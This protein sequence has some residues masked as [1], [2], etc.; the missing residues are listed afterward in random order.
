MKS[1][2]IV[3]D[4]GFGDGGKGLVVDHLALR[5]G[6]DLVVR[7]NGGA[8]AAHNVHLGDGRHHT[9]AQLGSATFRGARTL[10]GPNVS[11]HP[12]AL[13]VEARILGGKGVPNPLEGLAIHEDCPLITPFHQAL[14]RLRELARGG[15]R[16]GS[17][18]IGIGEVARDVEEG[19]AVRARHLRDRSSLRMR[20]RRLAEGRLALAAT[21]QLPDSDRVRAELAIFSDPA[22]VE[23]WLDLGCTLPPWLIDEVQAR[24][25]L[26]RAGHVVF[27][28]AQ[29]V[30][31][32]ARWGFHPFTTWS[33]CTFAGA[34]SLLLRWAP[35]QRA[36]RFGVMRA[37]AVRHGPGP[38]PTESAALAA[39][40][41]QEPALADDNASGEWQGPVRYGHWDAGLIAYGL[42]V[43]GGVDVLVTTWMDV[44]PRL[45]HWIYA[46]GWSVGAERRAALPVSGAPSVEGQTALG[47]WLGGATPTLHREAPNEAAVVER[48]EALLG[49][50]PALLARGRRAED[51]GPA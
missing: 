22:L 20:L 51:I 26:G 46:D 33:D 39:K 7:F 34:E 18:G 45:D 12:G 5:T 28:G 11:V 21:L 36:R 3:V 16:H 17:C 8:Q 48:I 35:E 15:E 40:L 25:L 6:A 19:S 31:L 14:N 38:L 24:S 50:R 32:D 41:A 47:A 10:L 23:R 37:F 30:L 2:S 27:E 44:L 4:L 13:L 42:R 49:V 9:F 29:G 43:L 1:A